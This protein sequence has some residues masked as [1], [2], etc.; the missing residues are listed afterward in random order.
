MNVDV[1]LIQ[2]TTHDLMHVKAQQS[3]FNG[4][5]VRNSILECLLRFIRLNYILEFELGT[6][7]ELELTGYSFISQMYDAYP[8]QTEHKEGRWKVVCSVTPSRVNQRQET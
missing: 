7:T 8:F 2:T 6:N 1:S 3:A 5:S 4:V